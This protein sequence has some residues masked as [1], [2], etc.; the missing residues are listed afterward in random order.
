[1][2]GQFALAYEISLPFLYSVLFRYESAFHIRIGSALKFAYVVFICAIACVYAYGR[3]KHPRKYPIMYKYYAKGF[4]NN[5]LRWSPI[6]NGAFGLKVSNI[7]AIFV[8]N[9]SKKVMH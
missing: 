7:N 1:M 9:E 4:L 2:C 8:E 3:R 6:T 5:S